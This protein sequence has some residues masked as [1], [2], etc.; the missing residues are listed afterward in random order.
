[1]PNY[2]NGKI[3]T[4]RSHETDEVYIGSTTETLAQ[5]MAKHRASM[6]RWKEGKHNY[7]TSFKILEYPT[8][9][10][11]LLEEYPC[12]SKME[13]EKK[14]GEYIRSM[15][16]V[17]KC[18]AGRTQ[19][20]YCQVNKDKI[21][22]Y[23]KEYRHDNKDELKEQKKQYYQDNKEYLDE[24]NKEYYENNKDE[25]KEYNKKYRTLNKDNIAL[26]KNIKSSIKK[27]CVCG[28]TFRQYAK[29]R[30]ERSIKHT[31]YIKNNPQ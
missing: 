23:Q 19:K 24:K 16:C 31:E 6:K 7:T 30:H 4:I 29:K 26:N 3:Y 25:I 15:E 22:E 9:Y 14:E 21:K 27:N 8:C 17:N 1:M 11:E 28:S 13:L 12:N 5:R 20:E 10:I 2:Q 18:V